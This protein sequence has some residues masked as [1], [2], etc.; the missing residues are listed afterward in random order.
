MQEIIDFLRYVFS[1]EQEVLSL[2]REP[3]INIYNRKLSELLSLSLNQS[4]K[5]GL[6]YFDQPEPDD[7]YTAI[8]QTRLPNPRDIFKV[9]HYQ[10]PQYGDLWA[11][12]VSIA[13]PEPEVNTIGECLLVARIES[14][15][16]IVAS[17]VFGDPDLV[18]SY[19]IFA[20]GDEELKMDQL[21]NVV[22]ILRLTPPS[23][24]ADSL[25]EYNK[26]S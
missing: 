11:C 13:D 5:F 8:Q 24:D 16:K 20:G 4:I 26:A 6:G 10:N 15:Y 12:Y 19:W 25:A 17:Y 23:D 22:E 18:K 7:F 3:D 9:S 21:G 2:M 1:V 14:D